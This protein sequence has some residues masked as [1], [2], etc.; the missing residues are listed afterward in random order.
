MWPQNKKQQVWYMNLFY[1]HGNSCST[2]TQHW[3]TAPC[4]RHSTSYRK[5]GFSHLEDQY[6][7][8]PLP[9]RLTGLAHQC[10]PNSA[11]QSQSTNHWGCFWAAG[12][13]YFWT[14]FSISGWIKVLLPTKEQ[15]ASLHSSVIQAPP[16]T[17]SFTLCHVY[18]PLPFLTSQPQQL[19][20]PF[21]YS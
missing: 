17:S 2:L 14:G 10:I 11:S 6:N 21:L 18:S 5:M 16:Y 20:L 7:S 9:K 4:F 13:Y 12:N 1:R 3:H 15:P 8:I 19:H